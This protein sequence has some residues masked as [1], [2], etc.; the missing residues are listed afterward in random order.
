MTST[1]E[2]ILAD[3]TGKVG[4]L[5]EA[6]VKL[7]VTNRTEIKG[8]RE[9]L[10]DM[11]SLLRDTTR[12]LSEHSE[13]ITM[14]EAKASTMQDDRVTIAKMDTRLSVLEKSVEHITPQKTPWTAIVSAVVAIGALAWTFFGK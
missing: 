13:R 1:I 3:L 9:D 6:Y 11:R 8:L 10:A 12:T 5:A 7:E 2:A 4:D 14:V